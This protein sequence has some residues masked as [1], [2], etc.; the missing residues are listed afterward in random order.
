MTILSCQHKSSA[1]HT[2]CVAGRVEVVTVLLEYGADINRNTE[3]SL[4][5]WGFRVIFLIPQQDGR[6]LHLALRNRNVKLVA[7]LLDH[8][9]KVA[10]VSLLLIRSRT[11]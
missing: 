10:T 6:P 3:V 8:H 5:L 4:S 1:L 11:N 9:P 7:S 2:A